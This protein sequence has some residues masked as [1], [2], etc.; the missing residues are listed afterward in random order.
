MKIKTIHREVAKLLWEGDL[1]IAEIASSKGICDRIIYRWKNDSDFDA[2]LTEIEE[3]H[4]T[5]AKREAIRWAR[6]SVKTLLKL[7]DFATS[8]DQQGKIVSEVF[9]FG[10]DVARKAAV[11]LLEMA[12]VK[13]N[14]EEGV[15]FGNNPIFIIQTNG[16]QPKTQNKPQDFSKR[17]RLE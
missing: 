15:G 5:A 11:D 17:F 8:K 2:V 7:Q 16:D 12:E 1:T 6:R 13:V 3:N 10:A 14:K 4:K 9:K